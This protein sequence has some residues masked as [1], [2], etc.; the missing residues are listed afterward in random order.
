M[1][2]EWPQTGR[3]HTLATLVL[4]ACLTALLVRLI[5]ALRQSGRDSRRRRK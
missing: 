2:R 4:I 3:V 1:R 5:M